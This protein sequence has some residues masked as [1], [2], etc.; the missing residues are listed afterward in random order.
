[1]IEYWPIAL[2]AGTG[3]VGYGELRAR[4][5]RTREDLDTKASKEVV[6][7]IDRRLERMERGIDELVKRG[8]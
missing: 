4:V 8:Q 2:V 5:T 7:Q 6:E 1:M 3:L